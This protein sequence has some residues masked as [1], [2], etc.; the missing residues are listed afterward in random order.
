MPTKKTKKSGLKTSVKS[1]KT[2]IINEKKVKVESESEV[3]KD[4]TKKVV[5]KRRKTDLKPTRASAVAIASQA[6]RAKKQALIEKVANS[7]INQSGENVAS[8]TKIPLWA[9]IFF[10]CSLLFFCISFYRAVILR[11][12]VEIKAANDTVENSVSLGDFSE[13]KGEE[14]D[15][16]LS[17]DIEED[18][19]LG[20]QS[21]NQNIISNPQTPE[22]LI[23]SFF[24]YMSDWKFD[25]SFALFDS[26]AQKDQKIRWYFGAFKMQPFFEWIEWKSIIPQN[27]QK[28]TGVYKWK[29]IY[30]FDISYILEST[31]EQYDETWEFVPSTYAWEWKISRIY[32][33]SSKCWNHPIFWPEDFGLMR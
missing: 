11:P 4:V 6:N 28:T 13:V 30:K 2:K 3:K 19:I 7:D 33:V 12:Q 10:G 27:I 15:L 25:E 18:N 22:E 16:W 32:C 8:N 20:M 1:E 29:N 17:D 9:R 5:I 26:S 14:W 24:A 21:V 31:H 23:Q